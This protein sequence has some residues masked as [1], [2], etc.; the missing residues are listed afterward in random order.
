MLKQSTKSDGSE[1]HCETESTIQAKR[2]RS[3]FGLL[4]KNAGGRRL[5]PKHVV[6]MVEQKQTAH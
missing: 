1:C 2:W 5:I 3:R 4:S 6:V